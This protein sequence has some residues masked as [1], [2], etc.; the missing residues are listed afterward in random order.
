MRASEHDACSSLEDV[1]AAIHRFRVGAQ[2][3]VPPKQSLDKV[4]VKQASNNAFCAMPQV[5]TLNI[6]KNVGASADGEDP[7]KQP[8]APTAV[9]PN[10]GG[11]SELR[12]WLSVSYDE[13]GSI[14]CRS[15]KPECSCSRRP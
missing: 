11:T 13:T 3:E 7:F 14:R 10:A 1:F 6:G 15:K 8:G 9:P 5:S 12:G 4:C 2:I